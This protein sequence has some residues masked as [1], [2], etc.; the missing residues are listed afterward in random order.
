MAGVL[1]MVFIA[2]AC[3][4]GDAEAIKHRMIVYDEGRGMLHYINERDDSKDWD[5]QLPKAIRDFQL[6]GNKQFIIA[7]GFGYSVYDL[8]TRK[9]VEDVKPAGVGGVMSARRRADGATILGANAKE[10][11]TIYEVD[12]KNAL[13]RKMVFPELK[14]LRMIRLTADGNV[15]IAEEGGIA[16]VAFDAQ[17]PSGGKIVKRIKQPAGRNSFMAL[18]RGDGYLDSAGFAK[19]LFEFDAE[20]KVKQEFSVKEPPAGVTFLFYAGFQVLKNGNIVVCNWTGHG[21]EDGAKGWQLVEF[22]PD[23]KLLWHWHDAKRASTL[24]NIA[25]LDDLDENKYLDDSSG[26][27]K[28]SE[29]K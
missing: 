16:E 27:L 9:L 20:G 29:V 10:G 4:A 28:E 12:K 21:P 2:T 22:A 8:E 18:K 15:M 23:D 26:V 25:V 5:L 3:W 1:A 19:A 7:Q 6:V 11:I 24:V 14:T 13:V 17:A